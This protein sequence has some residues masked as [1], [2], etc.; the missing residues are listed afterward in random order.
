M[1]RNSYTQEY[2]QKII[3]EAIKTGNCH[4]VVRHDDINPNVLSW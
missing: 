4:I 2:K 3:K 1:K